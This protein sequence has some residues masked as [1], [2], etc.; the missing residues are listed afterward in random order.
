MQGLYCISAARKKISLTVPPRFLLVLVRTSPRDKIT[1]VLIDIFVVLGC[2]PNTKEDGGE[3][4]GCNE[5]HAS[6]FTFGVGQT[7]FPMIGLVEMEV[8]C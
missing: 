5:L 1:I 8:R 6:T 3:E 7:C 4:D 2:E